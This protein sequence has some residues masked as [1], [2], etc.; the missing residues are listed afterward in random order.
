MATQT[1]QPF[2]FNE[3]TTKRISFQFVDEDQIALGSNTVLSTVTLTLYNFVDASIIN[4]RTNQDVLGGSKTGQNN[5]TIS[6]SAA[7]VWYVQAL[8]NVIVDTTIP[9]GHLEEHIAFFRWTWDP[10]DGNG[11]RSNSK[12][13][14]IQVKQMN[15]VP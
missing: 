5:V 6:A 15:K 10:A 13:I 3:R 8:D 14:R 12:E 1:S 9:I 11:V 4:N 7:L 2:V